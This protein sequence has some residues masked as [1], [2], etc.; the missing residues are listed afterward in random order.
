MI[1]RI[2]LRSGLLALL[3]ALPVLPAHAQ[4]P[5]ATF[6]VVAGTVEV[7]RAGRGDWQPA[8]VGSPV[9][10][11]DSVRTGPNGFAK[12]V[13][14]DDV[15]LDLGSTSELVVEQYAAGRGTRRSLLHLTQ[16]AIETWVAGYSAEGSRFEIETPTAVVRVQGT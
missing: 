11:D 16:G 15:V 1:L 3:T 12:L 13:F 5:A 7:Q 14:I 2:F 4:T 10:A 6:S 9:F 8:A